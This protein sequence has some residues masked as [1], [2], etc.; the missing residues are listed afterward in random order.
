[1]FIIII[2]IFPGPNAAYNWYKLNKVSIGITKLGLF[3]VIIYY[4]LLLQT[5]IIYYLSFIIYYLSIFIII[6]IYL[7]SII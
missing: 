1:M 6:I 7:L 4:H 3:I 2:V 5:Q